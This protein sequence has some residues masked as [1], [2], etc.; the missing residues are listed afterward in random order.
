M[1]MNA[2]VLYRFSKGGSS[3][4]SN[5]PKSKK[6]CSKRSDSFESNTDLL[7]HEGD[8][9]CNDV[10]SRS[11]TDGNGKGGMHSPSPPTPEPLSPIL[12]HRSFGTT[13]YE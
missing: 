1:I 4:N 12:K 10:G 5:F 7:S 8:V 9:V 11:G 3:T 6:H 2:I 13:T